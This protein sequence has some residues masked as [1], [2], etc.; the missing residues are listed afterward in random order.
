MRKTLLSLALLA[1][2]IAISAQ[3]KIAAT[4]A[5]GWNSWNHF[6]KNVTDKD[7]RTA[8]NELVSTGMKDAG[9]IYVNIDDAWQGKRDSNGHIVPATSG[10]LRLLLGLRRL[11]VAERRGEQFLFGPGQPT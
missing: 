11:R 10:G 5:M 1:L 4:P 7:V 6:A 9:Y 2:P 3:T 8:A